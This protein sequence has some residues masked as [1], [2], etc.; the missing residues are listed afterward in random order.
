MRLS[1]TNNHH[2]NKAKQKAELSYKT[3]KIIFLHIIF[4]RNIKLK[5]KQLK[6]K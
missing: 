2:L 5:T 4:C 1:F 3:V 6:K